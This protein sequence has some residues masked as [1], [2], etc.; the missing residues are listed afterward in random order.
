VLKTPAIEATGTEATLPTG[1]YV[2]S[3]AHRGALVFSL[4]VGCVAALFV[5][6]RVFAPL[7][8]AAPLPEI[9]ESPTPSVAAPVA[10]LL[11]SEWY[12]QSRSP[13][14][15]VGETATVT[16]QFRNVGKTA[17]VRGTAA[18]IRLGE[19]GDRPLPPEMHVDWPYFNRPAVQSES[20]VNA[21]GLATF[22][23]KVMGAAPGL[24]RLRLRPVVDGV[25]WLEDEG[26][27]VEFNVT[28]AR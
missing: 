10:E 7:D 14:I 24:F 6:P 3:S 26:V 16:L 19:V 20:V 21:Q 8:V 1:T 23:F 25:T 15:S 12:T 4:I 28:Q 5:V 18:E 11:H 2:R 22:T 13:E 17:W 27:Y 9:T